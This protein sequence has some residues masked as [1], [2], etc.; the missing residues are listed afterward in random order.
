MK[1]EDIYNWLN[2][3][4]KVSW[5]AWVTRIPVLIICFSSMISI[6]LSIIDNRTFDFGNIIVVVTVILSQI[7][8]WI[9]IY[10]V[11]GII[12]EHINILKPVR[13]I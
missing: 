7:C 5:W 2:P 9:L 1:L 3:K 8:F 12:L 10:F 11:G 6:I 4:A 13:K